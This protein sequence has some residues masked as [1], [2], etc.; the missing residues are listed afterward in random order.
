MTGL[1][2]VSKGI[3]RLSTADNGRWVGVLSLSPLF[4]QM[5]NLEWRQ[6]SIQCFM[7]VRTTELE[8]LSICNVAEGRAT[9]HAACP[10]L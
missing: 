1:E 6:R 5:R 4:P 8:A 7:L 9:P 2:A 3:I 10:A